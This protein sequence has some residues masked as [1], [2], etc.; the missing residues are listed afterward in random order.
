MNQTSTRAWEQ[1]WVSVISRD[2]I[3]VFDFDGTVSLGHGPIRAY[4]R[5]IADG[6]PARAATAF[7][8]AVELHLAAG[9]ARPADATIPIDGYDLVRMLAD[10]YDVPVAARNAA[11]LAS[12]NQLATPAAPVLPP[13]GLADFLAGAR[14]QAQLVLATNAP[15]IRI[16]EALAALGLTGAF[17]AVYT[18]VG[19]PAGFGPLLDE[20]L[21]ALPAGSTAG[22]GLL[23]IGDVWANDLAPAHARGASTALVGDHQPAGATPTY[24][25]T[26]LPE[27]YPALQAWLD[28]NAQPGT[29]AFGSISLTP[30]HLEKADS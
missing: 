29:T 30:A 11:Y 23:S 20:L 25:A 5:F 19:K 4:A 12:R 17:D 7:L 21:A 22:Q 18:S 14:A 6:L 26:H 9:A 13:A 16:D 27:L 3:V 8:G 15:P 24:R 10:G 2:R 1:E 28:S